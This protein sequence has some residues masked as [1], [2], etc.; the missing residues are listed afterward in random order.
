MAGVVHKVFDYKY[1][2]E[3]LEEELQKPEKPVTRSET[4]PS[5]VLKYSMFTRS[6]NPNSTYLNS[7]LKTKEQ[8]LENPTKDQI[9][10]FI[11]N[12][13]LPLPMVG[14]M[15]KSGR[16][17]LKEDRYL[18]GLPAP[19]FSVTETIAGS[20]AEGLGLPQI[21]HMGQKT[22]YVE[23]PDEDTKFVFSDLI[24]G[25]SKSTQVPFAFI[26]ETCGSPPSFVKLRFNNTAKYDEGEGI[27]LKNLSSTVMDDGYIERRRLVRVLSSV[28]KKYIRNES[29]EMNEFRCKEGNAPNITYSHHGPALTVDIADKLMNVIHSRDYILSLPCPKWPTQAKEWVKRKR[30]WPSKGIIMKVVREGCHVIP[31]A[32]KPGRSTDFLL[33]FSLCDR[34]IC[35]SLNSNQ[36]RCFMLFKF[37]FKLYLNKVKRGLSSY[38]CKL[39]FL[40][41]CEKKPADEWREDN[42]LECLVLLLMDFKDYL[43]WH[44][45]PNYYIP[46]HNM[47]SDLSAAVVRVCETDVEK[48]LKNPCQVAMDITEKH[49]FIWL[50]KDVSLTKVLSDLSTDVN[51]SWKLMT[52]CVLNFLSIMLDKGEV[53]LV[54]AIICKKWACEILP[55]TN[56]AIKALEQVITN[57][58]EHV[59]IVCFKGLLAN[60]Y[61]NLYHE[62]EEK[63]N[64]M[65][66]WLEKSLDMFHEILGDV[67]NHIWIYG[68]YYDLLYAFT[69]NEDLIRHFLSRVHSKGSRGVGHLLEGGIYTVIT[70]HNNR[71]TSEDRLADL[72]KLFVVPSTAYILYKVVQ[73]YMA[74]SREAGQLKLKL[75]YKAEATKVVQYLDKWVRRKSLLFP[76]NT[77]DYMY[78]LLGKAASDIGD[79]DIAGFAFKEACSYGTTFACI[80]FSNEVNVNPEMDGPDDD[81]KMQTG[82][83]DRRFHPYRRKTY[84]TSAKPNETLAK[85]IQFLGMDVRVGSFLHNKMHVK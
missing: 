62:E 10:N 27:V 18:C 21:T 53:H 36:K 52:S 63:C 19:V 25:S 34:T 37:I 44:C 67:D 72:S 35:Q 38:F 33:S 8:F 20:S 31:K 64:D 55:E 75:A 81:D 30:V 58:S 76:E 47:L 46:E 74:L 1:T 32:S 56:E 85:D 66:N 39:T 80:Q 2:D 13:L 28:L 6:Y 24:V 49:R 83:K 57:H 43:S 73:A 12:T 22:F 29:K 42:L 82:E 14:S 16:R 68:A 48:V 77:D 84:R 41:L 54:L 65:S 51:V 45:L 60:L 79:M 50:S 17:R 9:G 26:E 4:T 78:F 61:H 7:L 5:S 23:A 70:P 59:N 71:T 69:A 3:T 40:W 15:V 11:F